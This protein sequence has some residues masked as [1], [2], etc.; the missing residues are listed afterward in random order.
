MQRLSHSGLLLGLG[1]FAIS[2][3]GAS[4]ESAS[5]P[6]GSGSGST[7][8]GGTSGT[9]GGGIDPGPGTGSKDAAPPEMEVEKAFEA[10][11]ATERFVWATNPKTGRVAL[12]DAATFQVKTVAAGQGPTFIAAV[13]GQGDRAVVLNVLSDDATYLSQGLDGTLEVRTYAIAPRA[14]S[15]AISPDGRWAVAWTDVTRV[16]RPDVIEGFQ[17]ISIIDLEDNAPPSRV[18]VRTVGFRP[19]SVTFAADPPRVF[20]VTEDGITVVDLSIARDPRVLRTLKLDAADPITAAFAAPQSDASDPDGG[21]PDAAM[22]S[23]GGGADDVA[24][25]AADAGPRDAEDAG[26]TGPTVD[27]TA[28]TLLPDGAPFDAARDASTERDG[29]PAD[30]AVG[31]ARGDASIDGT[32]TPPV[33]GKADVSI[34]PDGAFAIFRR[35]GSA[36]VTVID[37]A[38]GSRWSWTLSGP[39]TDLDLADTGN[40]AVAVVRNEARIAVLPVPGRGATAFD[41]ISVA[42]ETVGSVVIAPHGELALLYTNAVAIND[43]TVLGLGSPPS[44]RSVA[45]HAPVLSVFAS[46]TAEHAVVVHNSFK[47]QAFTSPG[48]FSVMPLF[49]SQTPVIQATDAPVLSVAISPAGDRAIIPVRDDI[50]KTYAVYLARMPSLVVDRYALASPPTAAGF[51][52]SAGQA[53]VAQEHPGGRVSFIDAASEQVR[54]ITGF[55]LGAGVVEW[56]KKDGGK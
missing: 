2:G 53:F 20:A 46:P 12:I 14:N 43:I 49:G 24:L 34:T 6:R 54:T 30:G 22:D 45:L 50:K 32:T 55:E 21:A 13:P 37:L 40:R 23:D 17:Q 11:V 44:H 9:G 26:E 48:A 3:C 38:D 7:G 47:G 42:G 33:A 36:V 41:D 27:A 8:S 5:E 18:P 25:D 19:S 29:G 16:V 1:L 31:D 10:P 39:V 51:V 4:S 28:D 52:G 56:T 15:W 35:E